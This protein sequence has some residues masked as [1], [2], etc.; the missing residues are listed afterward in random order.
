MAT[1][2]V[3]ID[4]SVSGYQ[5]LLSQVP[6]GY[7]VLQV[8]SSA[9]GWG[10]IASYMAKQAAAGLGLSYSSLHIVGHGSAGSMQLGTST[11]SLGNLSSQTSA[12]AQI[13]RYMAPGADLMLY[14][15]D[16]GQGAAGNAFVTQLAKATGLDVAASTNATGGRTGDWVLEETVGA[17]QVQSLSLVLE[18]GLA[19]GLLRTGTGGNDTLNGTAGDDTFVGG[20]G[21]DTFLGDDG[22]DWA[23]YS[24][25]T[26]KVVV[27]L[28]NISQ[29]TV[30]GATYSAANANGAHGNDKL[31]S[32]EAVIGG[33]AGDLISGGSGSA[34]LMGGAGNDTLRG[35]LAHKWSGMGLRLLSCHGR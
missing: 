23:D 9:D 3:V 29:I 21:D 7:A 1:Q 13:Q 25:A 34:T 12:F 16:I 17:V 31:V 28:N 26:A 6:S 27:Q 30:E 18:R 24:T 32:I 20:L 35:R 5:S 15:C 2:L 11:L 8:D 33:S 19:A 10:Q 14:G 4:K 22:T